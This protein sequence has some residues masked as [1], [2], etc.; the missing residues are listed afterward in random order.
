MSQEGVEV[1]RFET[2]KNIENSSNADL[3]TYFSGV[4]SSDKI[5]YF[6]KFYRLMRQRS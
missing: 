1:S 5:N 3:K 2:K 4:Y 6:A